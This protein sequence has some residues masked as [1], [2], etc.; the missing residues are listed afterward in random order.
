MSHEP[1]SG[2]DALAHEQGVL[3]EPCRVA[4]VHNKAFGCR[5]K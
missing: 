3:L 2:V 5:E 1:D 4:A